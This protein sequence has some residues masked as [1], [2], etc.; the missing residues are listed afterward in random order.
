MGVTSY[1]GLPSTWNVARVTEELNISFLLILNEFQFN[2]NSRM[3][4][5]L[6]Y[7]QHRPAPC[8][9][10]ELSSGSPPVTADSF[11][12]A[13]PS[14]HLSVEKA[15]FRAPVAGS[16]W[17][18]FAL[19][20]PTL[21]SA[22]S[23]CWLSA[24]SRAS[25]FPCPMSLVIQVQLRPRSFRLSSWLLNVGFCGILGAFFSS[26]PGLLPSPSFSVNLTSKLAVVSC[27]YQGGYPGAF[28]GTVI[29][30]YPFNPHSSSMR[31]ILSSFPLCRGR[32]WSREKW[33]GLKSG[34]GC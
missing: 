29:H 28:L 3:G 24:S 30:L 22:L 18:A 1:V 11:L 34:T 16:C 5:G 2:W 9:C 7:G 6:L 31:Q 14:P 10:V 20:C 19:T 13:S 4:L 33:E 25:L 17:Q 23:R 26:F 32:N 27:C 21:I 8:R 12:L 15:L